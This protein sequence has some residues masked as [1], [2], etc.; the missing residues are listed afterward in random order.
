M[1]S[2]MKW[3]DKQL[4]IPGCLRVTTTE[5]S[6]CWRNTSRWTRSR[7]GRPSIS[8]SYSSSGTPSIAFQFY[9]RAFLSYLS[10]FTVRRF[11]S[12]TVFLRRK[13]QRSKI[14]RLA[15]R[16]PK[17]FPILGFLSQSPRFL[18]ANH[19]H[20]TFDFSSRFLKSI[21]R[22]GFST[23]CLYGLNLEFYNTIKYLIFI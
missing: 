20:L 12:K 19:K 21:G 9:S 16:F 2:S 10:L 1:K 14:Y 3:S 15:Y 13:S 23:E 6:T 4:N 7:R 5:S 18:F 22:P 17:D 8:T 11:L